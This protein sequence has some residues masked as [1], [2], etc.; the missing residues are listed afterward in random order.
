MSHPLSMLHTIRKMQQERKRRAFSAAKR[1][2]DAQ[3]ER[4]NALVEAVDTIRDGD[5][6]ESAHWVAQRQSWCL[7]M[8]MRR[9]KEQRQL[10]K[11]SAEAEQKHQELQAA[12]KDEQIV[13]LIFSEY[14]QAAAL[15]QRREEERLN[16]ELAA[17]GWWRQCG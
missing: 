11:H 7:Q 2:R 10:D 13:D 17:Q 4:L 3:E 14:K 1:V 9:R 15:E 6:S 12:S 8:E 16:N 5:D